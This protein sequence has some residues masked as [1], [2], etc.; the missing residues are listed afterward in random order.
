MVSRSQ[1]FI[2]DLQC[3]FRIKTER[4]IKAKLKKEKEEVCE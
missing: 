4:E 1:F 2:D 3:P